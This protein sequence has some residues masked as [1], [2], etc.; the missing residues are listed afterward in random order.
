MFSE[1]NE[2][3]CT[4]DWGHEDGGDDADDDGD[5]FREDPQNYRVYSCG[6]HVGAYGFGRMML[7]CRVRRLIRDVMIFFYCSFNVLKRP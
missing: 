3:A 1:L 7:S 2:H 5:K 6:R 4:P